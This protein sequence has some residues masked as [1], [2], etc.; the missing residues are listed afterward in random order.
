MYEVYIGEMLCPVT[1][2]K[3]TMK[4]KNQNTT[5]NLI[6]DGEINILKQAGL[7]EVSFDLL[8]P[9]VK[10]PF[11]RYSAGFKN[12]NYFL[13]ILEDLK[14]NKKPFRF[15][16]TRTLPNGKI[17]YNSYDAKESPRFSLEEYDIVEDAKEGFD[18]KVSVKLKQYKEYGTKTIKIVNKSASVEKKRPAD[19]SPTPSKNTTYTVVKGDCLWNIAKKFYGDGS[20]YTL[21]L[22]A[23]KDKIKNANLIYPGQ[24]LIIPG[25]SE[26]KANTNTSTSTKNTSKTSG[27]T[28]K[29]NDAS[30]GWKLTV[31]NKDVISVP[32]EV[33]IT[34]YDVNRKYTR[35]SGNVSV[36][37]AKGTKANV[38]IKP[39]PGYTF[40]VFTSG[41][42]SKVDKGSQGVVY[43]CAGDKSA[44]VMA[45]SWKKGLSL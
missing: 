5:M 19:N 26:V 30:S 15:K 40:T 2:S 34:Y 36:I 33:V 31:S 20:K 25:A 8:L 22:N 16:V 37:A 24:V 13:D 10:Y 43:T 23:N 21:I 17:L 4:I 11:A 42:W 18:V 7:T 6:N 29:V 28:P 27:T 14:V 38:G 12:A 35:T 9:N 3:I 45:I 1:P 41:K 44:C 39:N 32:G